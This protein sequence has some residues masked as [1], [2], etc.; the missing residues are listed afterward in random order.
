[1]ASAK[2]LRPPLV[3][4]GKELVVNTR[5]KPWSNL[6]LRDMKN[7]TYDWSKHEEKPA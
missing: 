6:Q 7:G 2:I 1:M 5:F 3:W 4:T